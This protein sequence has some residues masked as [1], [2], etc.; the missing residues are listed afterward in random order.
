MLNFNEY[1]ANPDLDVNSPESA[2]GSWEVSEISP[3]R[4]PLSTGDPGPV[5]AKPQRHISCGL[6]GERTKEE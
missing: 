1:Q 2:P 6:V 3:P 5:H 4:S